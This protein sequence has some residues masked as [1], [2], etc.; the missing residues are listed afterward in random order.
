MTEPL[1]GIDVLPMNIALLLMD[2]E[3]VACS[4]FK[5]VFKKSVIRLY[6]CIRVFPPVML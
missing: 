6:R 3:L 4:Y 2:V 5:F 1:H